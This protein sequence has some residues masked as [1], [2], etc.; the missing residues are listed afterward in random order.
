M[1]I[2]VVSA[3]KNPTNLLVAIGVTAI[4]FSMNYYFMSQLPGEINFTCVPKGYLTTGNI[5]FAAA[6]AVLTGV[7]IAGL[8][9]LYQYKK[10]S[11]GSMAGVTGVGVLIGTMTVFCTACTIPVISLFGFSVGLGFFTTYN[12]AFKILS[13]LVMCVGLYFLEKQ[14]RDQCLICKK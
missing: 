3:L 2:K 11:L 7:M 14:L 1:Q 13:L 6:L 4:F 5:V 9:E 12:L 10:R 8:M